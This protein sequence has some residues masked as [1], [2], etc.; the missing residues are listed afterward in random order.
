MRCCR[1]LLTANEE[2]CRTKSPWYLSLPGRCVSFYNGYQ[3][4]CPDELISQGNGLGHL[5][6]ICIYVCVCLS[7][8]PVGDIK[9]GI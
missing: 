9:P 7:C 2:I 3:G 4:T 6:Y 5:I 8:C 1:S